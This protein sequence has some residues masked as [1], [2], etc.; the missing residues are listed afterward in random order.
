MSA[1]SF[2][3]KVDQVNLGKKNTGRKWLS[4]AALVFG[5]VGLAAL[6]GYNTGMKSSTNFTQVA[7]DD[8]MKAYVNFISTYGK[9]YSSKSHVSKKYETF[10]KNY[11]K[12]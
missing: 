8:V 4:V 2:S 12:I 7:E 3:I 1:Q 11:E 5:V 6:T 9:Q 10:K